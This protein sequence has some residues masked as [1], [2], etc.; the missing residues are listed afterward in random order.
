MWI[1]H[2]FKET[3]NST[4]D[5]LIEKVKGR[6]LAFAIQ[7]VLSYLAVAIFTLLITVAIIPLFN[8][9]EFS[10]DVLTADGLFEW[11]RMIDPVWTVTVVVGVNY[12]FLADPSQKRMSFP[13]FFKGKSSSFWLDLVIALAV[14]AVILTV[15]YKNEILLSFTHPD[16]LDLLLLQGFE[17][18]EYTFSKLLSNWIYY[19]VWAS[20]V[21]AIFIIEIRERKRKGFILKMPIWKMLMASIVLSFIIYWIFDGLLFVFGE[22]IM[23]FLYIPFELIEI[24]AAFGVL[25]SILFKTMQFMFIAAVFHFILKMGMKK[26]EAADLEQN[27][28]NEI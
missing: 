24:P 1:L 9:G 6:F 25:V 28:I 20:P 27:T 21:V 12:L 5:Y 11:V 17:N 2:I 7:L 8:Q 23:S 19:V 15:Y 22:L 10:L 18:F 4:F 14:L 3:F 26:H 16:P 13:D